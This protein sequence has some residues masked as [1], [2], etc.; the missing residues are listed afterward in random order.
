MPELKEN[1]NSRSRPAVHVFGSDRIRIGLVGCGGRGRGAAENALRSRPS[2]QVV[3]HAVGD[4]FSQMVTGTA[5]LFTERYPEQTDLMPERQFSGLDCCQKVLETNVDVVLLCEPPGFRPRNVAAAI[6]A[7]KHVFAEKPVATDSHGVAIFRNAV[8]VA[9]E[10]GLSLMVGH[11]LR[12]EQKHTESIAAIHDG[13]I[14]D[15]LYCRIFFNSNGVWNRPRKPTETEMEHQINNWYYFNWLSG[16]HIVE[17]HVHDIDVMNWINKDKTPVSA[18]GMG[19]RA[20][21]IGPQYGEIFDHHS[22]EYFY[23]N[24]VYGFSNCR[25]IP[26][27]WDSFS[28]F[29]YGT[30]GFVAMQGHGNVELYV[31]GKLKRSWKRILDGHQTEM[32]VFFR[33]LSQGEYINTGHGGADATMTAILGRLATYTGNIIRWDDAV[34][35]DQNLF[36]PVLTWDAAPGPKPGPDGIYPCAQQGVLDHRMVA[37]NTAARQ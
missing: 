9:E 21:R 25:H 17:Q 15:L 28:E 32:D 30:K 24:G 18:N 16:D 12:Y 33:S 26:N 14:G 34:K 35:A 29:A 2:G 31:D 8:T 10:K 11:H 36:P 22:V 3:L 20:V 7:N 23:D 5:K 6:A 4:A 1:T 19:G 37:N 13:E 27:C